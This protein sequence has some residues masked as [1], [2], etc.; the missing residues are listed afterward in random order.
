MILTSIE[1]AFL[2][3]YLMLAKLIIY[4]NFGKI[5]QTMNYA[6]CHQSEKTLLRRLQFK[7]SSEEKPVPEPKRFLK[8]LKVPHFQFLFR[9]SDQTFLFGWIKKIEFRC[10]IIICFFQ[11]VLF[12]RFSQ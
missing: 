12:L 10:R 8:R 7:S 5:F 9:I 2:K 6:V 11:I 4:A 1:I 3:S